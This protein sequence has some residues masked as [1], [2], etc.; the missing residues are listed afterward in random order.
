L[1]DDPH[2]SAAARAVKLVGDFN[3]EELAAAIYAVAHEWVLKN[4]IPGSR[5][6]S[7]NQFLGF[8]ETQ[9]W[10]A[11][12]N[13]R[14]V[15]P[16]QPSH[17]DGIESSAKRQTIGG[18]K[19]AKL[20]ALLVERDGPNCKYCSV[21]LTQPTTTIDHVHPASL[22]GSDDID[23]LVLACRPCNSRKG[24]RLLAVQE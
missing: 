14:D 16:V 20:V 13:L 9:F 22:G 8:A 15:V 17:W 21:Q 24:D 6:I 2:N 1:Q 10:K 3:D 11:C 4:G 19:R 5:S 7:D 12:E 23:N 18:V